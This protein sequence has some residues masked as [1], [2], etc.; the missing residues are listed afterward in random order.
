MGLRGRYQPHHEAARN[1]RA[2]PC[3]LRGHGFAH[4]GHGHN[5]G[6]GS[7]VGEYPRLTVQSLFMFIVR[8]E[9]KTLVTPGFLDPE[10]RPKDEFLEEI[11]IEGFIQ[12]VW[13]LVSI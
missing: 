12:V 1:L 10:N 6:D 9:V 4:V 3:G 8:Q 13:N 5:V 7:R 2:E 11:H